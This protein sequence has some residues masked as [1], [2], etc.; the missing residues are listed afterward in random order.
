MANVEC[1]VAAQILKEKSKSE[2]TI[3]ILNSKVGTL[4][5]IVFGIRYGRV[6]SRAVSCRLEGEKFN[7]TPPTERRG[8]CIDAMMIKKEC[9]KTTKV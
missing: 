2:A 3:K 8:W 1:R 4:R 5:L 6:S 7:S 9:R